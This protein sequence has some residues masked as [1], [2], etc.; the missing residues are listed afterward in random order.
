VTGL[1]DRREQVA[2]GVAAHARDERHAPVD[3]GGIDA[4]HERDRLLRGGRR[5]DLDADRV[6]QERGQGDVGAVDLA[7]AV[8]DPQ[9][10]GRQEEQAVLVEAQERALV[11]EDEHLVARVEL[12]GRRE[13][14][15]TPH[16]DM[17]RR[18]RSISV[19][20]RS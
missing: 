19:D 16:A 8:A 7:G 13:L 14:S 1:D 5:P 3:T 10:V 2:D 20:T 9:P 17:N 15:S 11:V 6:G 12:D 4:L 18:L